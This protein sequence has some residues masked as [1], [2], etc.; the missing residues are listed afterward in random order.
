M[1]I[2][3]VQ[4]CIDFDGVLNTYKGYKGENELYEP[5]Q[6]AK[7][8]LDRLSEVYTIIIFT[9]RNRDK[10][11]EW[12]KQYELDQYVHDVTDIKIPAIA[13]IDDRALKFDGDYEKV[14]DELRDFKVHWEATE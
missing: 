6:G 3:K 4:L 5:R 10:V 9:T 14:I 12:L 13:Y 7:E 8:F 11:L 2:N 1:K